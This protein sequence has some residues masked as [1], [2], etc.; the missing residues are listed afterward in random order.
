MVRDRHEK[1]VEILPDL[2]DLHACFAVRDGHKI[3]EPVDKYSGD[4]IASLVGVPAKACLVDNSTAFCRGNEEYQGISSQRIA[5]SG[6][7]RGC[8]DLP[9]VQL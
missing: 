2:R 1:L 5:G 6:D 8:S 4:R 3:V 7:Q 9:D